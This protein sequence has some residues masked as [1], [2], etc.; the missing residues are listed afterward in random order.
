M[1]H[2]TISSAFYS[3]V[4]SIRCAGGLYDHG[5]DRNQFAKRFNAQT[6]ELNGR[7][8]PKVVRRNVKSLPFMLGA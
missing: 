7:L 5:Y 6:V 2:Q 4:V 1:Q 8:K 3:T